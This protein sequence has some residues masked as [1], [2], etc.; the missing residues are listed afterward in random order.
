LACLTQGATVA[1]EAVVDQLAAPT[2]IGYLEDRRHPEA[3]TYEQVRRLDVPMN[4][5]MV[6][7]VRQ[8]IEEVPHKV[9]CGVLIKHTALPTPLGFQGLIATLEKDGIGFSDAGQSSQ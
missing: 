1:A 3:A 8:P 7:H 2:E 5:A 6:V 9:A 4:N